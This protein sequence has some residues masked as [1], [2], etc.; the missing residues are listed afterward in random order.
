MPVLPRKPLYWIA[1]SR[2]DL[3][4]LPVPVQKTFGV[5]LLDVQHGGTPTHAVPL[6][7]FAGAGVL[8]IVE[9]FKSDTY[10]AVYTVNFPGAVYVLHAFQ[11]KSKRGIATPPRD[12]ALVRSRYELARQHYAALQRQSR[13]EGH[14]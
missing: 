6:K 10:R 4:A 3:K 8:E 14:A 7:G 13:E 2:K 12:I 1:S 9:D 5:A 11:K